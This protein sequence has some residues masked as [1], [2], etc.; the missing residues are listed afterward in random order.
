MANPLVDSVMKATNIPGMGAA[1]PTPAAEEPEKKRVIPAASDFDALLERKSES[2][3]HEIVA[4][5]EPWLPGDK[6][7]G[8]GD[9]TFAIAKAYQVTWSMIPVLLRCKRESFQPVML[10]TPV[11]LHVVRGFTR[12]EWGS[13]QQEIARESEERYKAH[14]EAKANSN[15]A[16]MDVSMRIEEMIAC[17]ACV[18]PDYNRQ[19]L[20]LQPAGVAS[21]IARAASQASMLEEEDVPPPV[22]L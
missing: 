21:A 6:I 7:P 10:W 16:T 1:A 22:K 18:I 20:R 2:A 11:G 3:P 17:K 5:E 8:L 13:V 12:Q 19:T 9:V 14:A 15:W 4:A